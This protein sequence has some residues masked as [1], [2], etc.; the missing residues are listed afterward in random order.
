MEMRALP[1][2]L[3]LSGL[4]TPAAAQCT[5]TWLPTLATLGTNGS[6]HASTIWDPDGPGPQ[7]PRLVIAGTF[8]SAFGAAVTNIAA[9]DP[10]SGSAWALGSGLAGPVYA[11]TTLP[12]GDLVAGGNF[13]QSGAT[14]VSCLARWNGAAWLPIGGGVSS[15][16]LASVYALTATPNGDLVAG[17]LFTNAGSA[18][19]FY[20]ARWNGTQWLS[21]GSGMNSW[22]SALAALPNGDVV[23]SGSFTMAGS[24]AANRIARWDGTTWHPLG[25]GVSAH[26]SSLAVAANGD[27]VA[28][29][30]FTLAGGTSANHV[31]RWNGIT[32]SALGAGCNGPVLALHTES[33]GDVV[34]GGDFLLAGN[35]PS[36]RVARWSSNTWQPLGGGLSAPVRALTQLPDGDLVAGGDFAA[37]ATSGFDRLARFRSVGWQVIAGHTDPNTAPGTGG[38]SA[39]M[40]NG[41][42][43][44]AVGSAVVRWNG[45][46]WTQLG[47]PLASQVVCL[48]VSSQGVLAAGGNFGAAVLT[49]NAWQ[50][51]PATFG[52]F[53]SFAWAANNDLIAAMGYTTNPADKVQGWNGSAWIPLGSGLPGTAGSVAIR[54]NGDIVVGGSIAVFPVYASPFLSVWNG[55][56][57][58]TTSL[59]SNV[60]Y[61]GAPGLLPMPNGDVIAYGKLAPANHVVRWDGFTATPLGTFGGTGRYDG[62]NWVAAL[63]TGELVASSNAEATSR[64][65]G[66]AWIPL[67]PAAGHGRLLVRPSGEIVSLDSDARFFSTCF[68]ATRNTTTACAGPGG[69]VQL[70]ANNLPWIGTTF[71][72]TANGFVP[73]ALAFAVLGYAP[74]DLPLA[75]VSA[76]ALPNCNLLTTP[77]A[78]VL[79]VPSGGSSTWTLPIPNVAALIGAQLFHQFVQVEFGGPSGIQSLSASNRL[80]LAIGGY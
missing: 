21:L 64:W 43:I 11:L 10:Q 56:A 32:W 53:Q 52:T 30:W 54:A 6:I 66:T 63:P 2:L 28:G 45:A 35:L 20:I 67:S 79:Q 31:A 4:T 76:A 60:L 47:S 25:S 22:V 44:A 72:S 65:N 34:V 39:L 7:R 33:N 59:A 29:G 80:T 19:T 12:N 23:A 55:T 41:D 8:T 75:T 48:A 15:F 73:G 9:M 1:T 36:N 16:P 77:D 71:A 42:M 68:A 18:T 69:P 58:Q 70:S 40:P 37:T 38:P 24:V 74:L 61:G 62:A 14:Y 49:G 46:A 50:L 27:I 13:Y 17:G 57:W 51:L 78:T 3:I 5:S 26:A